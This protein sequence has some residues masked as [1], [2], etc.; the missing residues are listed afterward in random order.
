MLSRGIVFS[1]LP[2]RYALSYHNA[3][4]P[5]KVK[6]IEQSHLENQLNKHLY[7]LLSGLFAACL[8][9]SAF[10]ATDSAK[11]DAKAMQERAEGDYKAA[12]AKIK[13]E[14]EAAEAE[15]KKMSGADKR[16][17]NKDAKAKEKAAQKQAKADYEK[18]KADAKAMK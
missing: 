3:A 17:C 5:S 18:A 14:N 13:G 2:P 12:K 1:Q 11:A 16:A 7:G 6:L 4:R 9:I 8:S 10:A 15:C